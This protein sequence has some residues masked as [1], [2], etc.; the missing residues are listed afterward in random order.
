MLGKLVTR[1]YVSEV[2]IWRTLTKI[3]KVGPILYLRS[4]LEKLLLALHA[5][6][7]S[8]LHLHVTSYFK[9]NNFLQYGFDWCLSKI[10]IKP[11]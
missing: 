6:I 4:D 1:T 2:H 9:T 8:S 5:C 3:R 7:H 11:K 10:C